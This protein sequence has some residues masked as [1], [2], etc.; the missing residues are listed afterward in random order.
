[1]RFW[2]LAVAQAVLVS[3]VF[4]PMVAHAQPA[5][6][7]APEPS[8]TI[9]P[10]PAEPAWAV[11]PRVGDT[12]LLPLRPA[13]G[14]ADPAT[15]AVLGW[16]PSPAPIARLNA[17]SPPLRTRLIPL[18]ADP[19]TDPLSWLPPARDYVAGLKAPRPAGLWLVEVRLPADFEA[20]DTPAIT[21]GG[22]SVRVA[23]PT[24]FVPRSGTALR[25]DQRAR[26]AALTAPAAR[27]PE[28]RWR[29]ALLAGRLDAPALLDPAPADP[30]AARFAQAVT[31]RWSA[32]LARLE[33]VDPEAAHRLVDRLTL[34]LATPES[35]TLP[36]WPID[37][38]SDELL[39]RELL[40]PDAPASTLVQAAEAWWARKPA[41]R[42]WLVDDAGPL[43]AGRAARVAVANLETGDRSIAAWSDTAG[44]RITATLEART[45]SVLTVPVGSG[46]QP[47]STITLEAEGRAV[48]TVTTVAP[49]LVINAPGFTTPLFQPPLA[50]ASLGSEQAQSVPVD[51]ATRAILLREPGLDR[52]MLHIETLHAPSD[53]QS[54]ETLSLW[55]GPMNDTVQV[56]RISRDGSTRLLRPT[57]N[58]EP[59]EVTVRRAHDR[60]TA[61]ILFHE[62]WLAD[63]QG[64]ARLA[65]TRA[66]ADGRTLAF[67]RPMWPHQSEPGRLLLDLSRWESPA[68]SVPAAPLLRP[69]EPD[70]SMLR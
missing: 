59:P 24:S 5:D 4:G 44:Q 30:D 39:L 27:T 18:V 48:G 31:A 36:G 56:V 52:W 3:F 7:R 29:I 50:L 34:L 54:A 41:F 51:H 58:A 40:D 8:P 9:A 61:T 42:A 49:P 46:E 64:L 1:M 25:A 2:R 22:R 10:G 11:A 17:E 68:A 35:H 13:R 57:T 62:T 33:G 55:V 63:E 65:I 23:A 20:A 19:P 37:P 45:I 12:V 28:Q 69:L 67:P 26:L 32:A 47:A 16:R 43:R 66:A 60:W 70:G 6:G 15:A 21:L 14:P 53:D 38:A